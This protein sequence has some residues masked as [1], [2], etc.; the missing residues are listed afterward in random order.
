[1]SIVKKED[2][3]VDASMLLRRRYKILTGGN[4]K[5]KCGVETAPP[6][7]SS[8]IQLPNS[9]AIADAKKCLMTET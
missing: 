7:D 2:Q 6:G 5:T 1:V 8:H 3:S 4:M 9:D